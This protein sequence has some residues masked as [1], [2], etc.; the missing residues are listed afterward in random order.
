[1]EP[2]AIMWT[3]HMREVLAELQQRPLLRRLQVFAEQRGVE[4]YAVGG[5][6]RDLCLGHPAHD[7][8]LV[9]MGDAI[10]FS[11]AFANSLG[12]AFVPMDAERGEVRVVYRKR[13]LLDFARLKGETIIEDLHYR[14][15]TIN[16]MACRL[17][18]LL[19]HAAPGLI[20]PHDGWHDLQARVIRMVSP[21]SFHEDPLRLL[22]AFRLAAIFDFV[23][24]PATLAAMEPAVP[25]LAD[26]A[27]ERIHSELLKL[28]AASRSGSHVVAMARLNLLDVLLPELAATRGIPWQS[29]DR[30]DTFE[31]A[32]RTLQAVEDLINTPSSYLSA[33]GE[34]VREYFHVE[35]HRAL[36]KWAALLHTLGSA[37]MCREAVQAEVVDH[38]AP[39]ESAQ[40]WEQIGNRFKLSRK[41]IEYGRTLI[42][43]CGRLSE[44]AT[45]EAQ[46]HLTLR[47]V[48]GWCKEMGEDLLGVFVLAIGHALAG[49][50]IDTPVH[51]AIALGD[52]AARVWH[53]YQSRILPV[54][55]APR[56]VSG[57]DL[58]Q[59][60]NLDPGP[61]FKTLLEGL[62]MAQ[63][64]GRIHTRA[65]ALQWVA[66]QLTKL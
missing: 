28:F 33:L 10:G 20:D 27:A 13:E 41:Q 47:V 19:T 52:C 1:M 39:E 66:K 32:L 50:Q 2:L 24:D 18:T 55:K 57:H 44:L 34:E 46:G 5:T 23:I 16:A 53:L 37:G 45:L 63:V 36:V 7:V 49:D 48:H 65:E 35:E 21:M 12:A 38:C 56:L 42:A 14:D 40:Q 51:G 30:G 54:I 6:L 8:D 64:E 4:L 11:K 61:R 3:D 43:H 15:F 59:I 31:H 58:R 60:F 17:A 26:V 25:R 22:R 29:A 9:I 62:E